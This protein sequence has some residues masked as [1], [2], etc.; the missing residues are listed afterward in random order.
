[1][2]GVVVVGCVARA[3]VCCC[4]TPFKK[5]R[6]FEYS[7][8]A[9][10]IKRTI[11]IHP[12]GTRGGAGLGGSTYGLMS[13]YDRCSYCHLAISLIIVFSLAN[14]WSLLHPLQVYACW[15][16]QIKW[17]KSFHCWRLIALLRVIH[18]HLCGI[19]ADSLVYWDDS[20][21]C[22]WDTMRN[23]PALP[24]IHSLSRSAEVISGIVMVSS[25]KKFPLERNS[26]F[27]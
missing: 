6:I 21:S 14:F 18:W 19:I 17:T 2:I 5:R 11:N 10:L 9:Q 25:T 13:M 24:P 3:G 20:D 12:S 26:I 27:H 16:K 22:D 8:S 4:S 15:R 7:L 23:T 1:M